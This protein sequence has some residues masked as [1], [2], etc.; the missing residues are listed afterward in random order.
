[1][2]GISKI[3]N[4]A[5]ANIS[6]IDNVLKGNI[7]NVSGIAVPTTSTYTSTKAYSLDGINDYAYVNNISSTIGTWGRTQG[8]Y[9]AWVNLDNSNADSTTYASR[10]LFKFREGSGSDGTH[11]NF[12]GLNLIQVN[13][14]KFALMHRYRFGGNTGYTTVVMQNTNN[15][16]YPFNRQ[17]QNSFNTNFH[18]NW[19]VNDTTEGTYRLGHTYWVHIAVTWDTSEQYTYPSGSSNN[20]TGTTKIYINGNL[21]NV[22]Q[23]SKTRNSS[24]DATGFG[25]PDSQEQAVAVNLSE[26]PIV[27]GSNNPINRLD[28]VYVGTLSPSLVRLNMY[29]KDLAMWNTE[30]SADAIATIAGQGRSAGSKSIDLNSAQGNYTSSDKNALLGWWR[31]E[32]NGNDE[33][34]NYNNHLTFVGETTDHIISSTP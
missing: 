16:G 8:S 23:G 18:R 26:R 4:V 21:R 13:Y 9:S 2:S 34:D 22:G 6:H 31:F 1:M 17:H 29:I 27:D 25:F 19:Y 32:T 14:N 3:N 11:D 5:I 10:Y 33:S 20:Y 12:I 7:S 30:L 28:S 15:H 24:N